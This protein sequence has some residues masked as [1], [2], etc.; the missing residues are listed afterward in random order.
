MKGYVFD[1]QRFALH[2]G[3]GI[4]TTIFL[5]G[6]PLRCVWCQNPEG[7]EPTP[8]VV[9]MEKNCIKCDLCLGKVKRN[10][11]IKEDTQLSLHRQQP[12]NWTEI[13][14]QCPTGALRYDCALY[15]SEEV[16][17]EALK[18]VVFFRN[19]GGVTISGG[20]PFYQVDFLLEIVKKLKE[21]K[22]HTTIES[23]LYTSWEN[24]EKVLPYIDH[25]YA[26]LKLYDNQQHKVYTGVGN[27]KI[28]SNLKRLLQSDKK[29]E[30]TIR[31]P[32]IPNMSA[33][34]ENITSIAQ[35]LT[36]QYADCEYELLNY[37]PLAKA[38]YAM[39]GKTYCFEDNP[40][41]F[42]DAQMDAFYR[43]A[44]EGGLTH[45]IINK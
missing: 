29:H 39:S 15:S 5:K 24:I 25:I 37:N 1:I 16:V 4:R 31:T 28:L 33:T 2:D 44:K 6:C 36:A 45:L 11:L 26:D 9:Y 3:A 27:T 14:D 38:K 30:I 42:N 35:F 18:D 34:K 7:L 8:Q 22:I 23:S 19:N 12:E 10:G 20:E 40:A 21:H 13:I 43:Y 17:K 41:M 32:L